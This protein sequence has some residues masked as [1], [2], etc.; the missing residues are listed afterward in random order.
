MRPGFTL[1]ELLVVIA[2]IAVLIALLLP[3]VQAAREAA[4]RAQCV[5][6][7]K[8]VG[9]ALHNYHSGIGSFPL[10]ATL[11]PYTIGVGN[12]T[13]SSWSAHAQMLPYMEQTPIYNAINFYYG[14][15]REGTTYGYLCNSTS[16][17]AKITSFECP[18]DGNAGNPKLNSYYA[19]MGTSMY[20]TAVADTTGLFG[21]QQKYT[22]ADVRDGTSNTIAFAEGIVGEKN[23]T[24]LGKGNATGAIANGN[25]LQTI[26][27][28]S[29][30]LVQLKKD[31]QLCDPAFLTSRNNDRGSYWG[32]G[33]MGQTMF[34]TVVTP[35]GSKWSACRYG[36]C[37]QA[38]HAEMQVAGSFHSGGVNVALADGSVRFIKD[39]ISYPTWWALGTRAL[40]ETV[41]SDS[42]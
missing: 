21:Y 39:S 32:E 9:L 2:I 41:S 42:Y 37:P 26:Y 25:G 30:K 29:G 11:Q 4:R 31:M 22:I 17:L 3:A 15:G 24:I 12:E 7:L 8:Q 19:S 5:N 38:S 23:T 35:N 34:N 40:G 1:I 6:N 20:S 28:D 27:D 36:C 13:W 14:A 16:Y 18:S 10:G 33:S